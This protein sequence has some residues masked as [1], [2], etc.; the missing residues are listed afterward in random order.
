M[1][2]ITLSDALQQMMNGRKFNLTVCT[3]DEKKK[4]GGER[5]EYK[6]A[7][8]QSGRKPIVKD[9]ATAALLM[10]DQEKIITK[11]PH[12]KINCTRNIVLPSGSIRKI[13]I[14]LIE[15]FNNKPVIL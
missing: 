15:K 7:R 5:I 9:N 3:Y 12:H 4:S 2:H 13:H 11:N 14:R 1:S 6:N 8:L 10:S